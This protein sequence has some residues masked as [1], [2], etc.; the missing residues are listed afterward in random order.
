MGTRAVE[1]SEE[2]LELLG[3]SRLKQRPLA[4]RVAAALATH[5]YVEGLVSIGK[6]AELA[7]ESRMEFEQLLGEIGIPVAEYGLDDYKQDLQGMAEAKLA[8]RK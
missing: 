1:I 7:G 5:L 4:A 3:E 2:L 8:E 6:A